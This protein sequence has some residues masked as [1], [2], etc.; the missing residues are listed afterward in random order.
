MSDTPDPELL[1]RMEDAML[2]MPKM[3]REIFMAHRLDDISYGEIARRTGL[4]VR[5]V[6]RHLARA[7]YKLDKQLRGR[8][9]SCWER[10]F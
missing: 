3:Q 5:Q 2:N 10:W 4:T 1:R 7:I 9:L 8:K 6:E